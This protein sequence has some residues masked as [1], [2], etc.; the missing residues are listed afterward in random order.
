MPLNLD[1]YMLLL[2]GRPKFTDVVPIYH[3]FKW[4]ILCKSN[5]FG[6]GNAHGNVCDNLQCTIY[7]IVLQI[8]VLFEN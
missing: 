7:K 8:C 6:Y 5:V 3:Y 4:G 2:I 1:R